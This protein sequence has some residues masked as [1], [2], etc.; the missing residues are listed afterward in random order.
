MNLCIYVFV[1][2]PLHAIVKCSI[3]K[4]KIIGY[5]LWGEK[6]IS[7]SGRVQVLNLT[8]PLGSSQDDLGYGPGSGFSLKPVQTSNLCDIQK[9]KKINPIS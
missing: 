3:F 4:K 1:Y 8:V 6:K 9:R 7:G 2:W 5:L